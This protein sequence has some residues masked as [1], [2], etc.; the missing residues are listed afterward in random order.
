MVIR[1]RGSTLQRLETALRQRTKAQAFREQVNFLD[2]ARLVRKANR[3]LLLKER[4]SIWA[5]R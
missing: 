3:R 5:M 4:L 1:F 2:T